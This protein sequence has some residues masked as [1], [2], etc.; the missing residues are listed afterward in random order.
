MWCLAVPWILV[1]SSGSL[2]ATSHSGCTAGTTTPPPV[3]SGTCHAPPLRLGETAQWRACDACSKSASLPLAVRTTSG[4]ARPE[5]HATMLS[6]VR[7]TVTGGGSREERAAKFRDGLMQLRMH[8][9]FPSAVRLRML[10]QEDEVL[11]RERDAK[12]AHSG[13]LRH[14]LSAR[15]HCWGLYGDAVAVHAYVGDPAV[16]FCMQWRVGPDEAVERE[17]RQERVTPVALQPVHPDIDSPLWIIHMRNATD[18]DWNPNLVRAKSADQDAHIP[19]PSSA[20]EATFERMMEQLHSVVHFGWSDERGDH[21]LLQHMQQ[22]VFGVSRV[23]SEYEQEMDARAFAHLMYRV[24]QAAGEGTAGVDDGMAVLQAMAQ[25][26]LMPSHSDLASLMTVT[27][28]VARAGGEAAAQEVDKVLDLMASLALPAPPWVF[29]AAFEALAW[30]ARAGKAG[31]DEAEALLC[32]MLDPGI[33][34]PWSELTPATAAQYDVLQDPDFYACMLAVMAGAALSDASHEERMNVVYEED[35]DGMVAGAALGHGQAP[36]T[37]KHHADYLMQR[38]R[39]AGVPANDLVYHA[40]LQVAVGCSKRGEMDM[41][42]IE[43][44]LQ[45]HLDDGG[46]LT[47]AHAQS[48]LAAAVL[49]VEADRLSLHDLAVLVEYVGHAA[50]ELDGVCYSLWLRGV[51]HGVRQ[52]KASIQELLDVMDQAHEHGQRF[53]TAVL[54]VLALAVADH[55]RGSLHENHENRGLE[56]VLVLQELVNKL[57]NKMLFLGGTPPKPFFDARLL[58]YAHVAEAGQVVCGY[59][60]ECVAEEIMVA[61]HAPDLHTVVLMLRIVAASCARGDTGILDVARIIERAIAAGV[62]AD[63]ALLLQTM[64]AAQAAASHGGVS[65]ADAQQLLARAAVTGSA[66]DANRPR[67]LGMLLCVAGEAAQHGLAT[68]DESLLLVER[69]LQALREAGEAARLEQRERDALVAIL[70]GSARAG[71]ATAEEAEKVMR[72]LDVGG[73]R[74]SMRVLSVLLDVVL[75]EA[76]RG[77]ATMRDAAHVLNRIKGCGFGCTRVEMRKLVSIVH[78]S[79]RHG[80]ADLTDGLDTLRELSACCTP[81]AEDIL[82]ILD[83]AQWAAYHRAAKSTPEQGGA[84]AVS[85]LEQETWPQ[86]TWRRSPT[87]RLLCPGACSLCSPSAC[88]SSPHALLCS[89][90]LT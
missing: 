44:L 45:G 40:R 36:L 28:R 85:N 26:G 70:A 43:C 90:P 38:M 22:G 27:V 89:A 10:R 67:V 76:A 24:V 33:Q 34:T 61:G 23:R 32:R 63:E 14:L 69:L 8:R 49:A 86:Q 18:E 11:D 35:E 73:Q 1:L 42:Q 41:E 52:G 87:A 30:S 53:N 66:L 48:L 82:Q 47:H 37:W 88:L 79:A 74:P 16:R 2:A 68:V 77:Q 31:L 62:A 64:A 39:E 46:S 65:L 75:A 4:G 29:L 71:T 81:T 84:P 60:G 57:S 3:V 12:S 50:L 78:A 54:R 9:F 55:V 13:H 56:E 15:R 80:H 25:A 5:L 6:L 20:V 59:T 72:H 21:L 58:L 7:A 17:G 19:D 83:C 51:A